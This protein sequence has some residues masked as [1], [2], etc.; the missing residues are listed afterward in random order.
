[1]QAKSF[2]K[3]TTFCLA[4]SLAFALN[5]TKVEASPYVSDHG[6]AGIAKIMTEYYQK[7][8]FDVEVDFTTN[9]ENLGVANVSGSLNIRKEPGEDKKKVGKLPKDA[10]MEILELGEDGWA[11]IKSGKI[12]GYVKAS[13]LLT[14]TQAE[15]RAKKV[16]DLVATVK[17][18]AT[19]RVRE[20]DNL[21]SGTLALVG[22]GEELEVVKVLPDWVQV[23]IDQDEGFV[24]RQ[25]VD[26]SYELKKAVNIEEEKS[27]STG[28]SKRA[29]MVSFA[30]KYLGGRYVWGGTSLSRGV[31]C[32]GFTQAIYRNFGM[33]IPRV[34]R[35]QATAGR[36]IKASNAKPGDLFFYG[37]GNYI[38]HV[39]MYIGNGQVI[40]ASNKRSGIKIS[41]AYYRTP[42]K[43]VRY[44]ND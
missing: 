38:N 8:S 1:M 20:E 37:K 5:V 12:Q 42:I 28:S 44:F 15:E 13:Y 21:L 25:Y 24:S 35:A 16:A 7:I 11:K 14:G 26:L 22:E 3:I 4:G 23:K 33:S 43:V 18:T 32:S 31:D 27:G 29:R 39:A 6:V 19:L 41:N 10:G 36:S 34:S 17:D 2:R 40:H 30:K 9:Y